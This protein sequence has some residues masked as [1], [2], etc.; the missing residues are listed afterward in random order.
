MTGT[1][2]QSQISGKPKFCDWL[3]CFSQPLLN[4]RL[5]TY[6][7]SN[8]LPGKSLKSLG[9]SSFARHYSRNRWLLSIP[10][11]TKMFQFPRL[12]HPTLYIQ[13]SVTRHYSSRVSP[14]GHPRFIAYLAA[15][16]GLSQ[17]ITSFFGVNTSRHSLCAL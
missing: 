1:I 11:G 12:P 4:I 8:K 3:I 16:R 7:P 17:P 10:R 9:S 6:K 2:S 15:P 5:S 14:F 13:V